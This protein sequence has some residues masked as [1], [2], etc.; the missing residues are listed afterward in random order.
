MAIEDF[1]TD[2]LPAAD[3]DADARASPAHNASNQP[4]SGSVAAGGEGGVDGG[5]SRKGNK[6]SYWV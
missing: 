2:A 3:D 4:D 5:G 1:D 6:D